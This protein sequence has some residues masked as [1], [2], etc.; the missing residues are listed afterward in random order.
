MVTWP[1]FFLKDTTTKAPIMRSFNIFTFVLVLT[2]IGA[3]PRIFSQDLKLVLAIDQSGSMEDN[4]HAN[5]RIEFAKALIDNIRDRDLAVA[6]IPWGGSPDQTR[7]VHLTRDLRKITEQ[8]DELK[9]GPYIKGDTNIGRAITAVTEELEESNPASSRVA[10]IITDG[11]GG[12]SEA[13]FRLAKRAN[14]Q[15]ITIHT[16]GV[17]TVAGSSPEAV[18]LSIAEA[19]GGEYRVLNELAVDAVTELLNQQPRPLEEADDEED[20][21]LALYIRMQNL[22]APIGFSLRFDVFLINS[23]RLAVPADRTYDIHLRAI[24]GILNASRLMIPRGD[25]MA[26]STIAPTQV[27]PILLSATAEHGIRSTTRRV[28]GCG[29]GR[30]MDLV[31]STGQDEVPVNQDAVI[32]LTLTDALGNLVTDGQSKSLEL[33]HNGTGRT[34]FRRSNIVGGNECAAELITRSERP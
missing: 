29:E 2:A 14:S 12:H 16:V 1:P 25:S 3:V 13:A 24:G 7:L 22:S 34:I 32:E 27:G 18:L 8:L 15:G 26:S 10:V 23:K 17:G 33:H 5:I 30:V 28:Y 6:L 4:D 20:D 19:T 11:E 9:D 21:L 31:F